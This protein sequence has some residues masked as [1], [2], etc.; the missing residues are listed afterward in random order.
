MSRRV[1]RFRVLG[2]LD[3]AGGA[4]PGTVEVDRDAGTLGVRPLRRR[5]VYSLPLSVVATMVCQAIVN[6]EARQKRA[7]KANGKNRK[8]SKV[9]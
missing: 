6:A 3:M 2:R 5:R 7:A 8:R 4:I 9:K 1:S